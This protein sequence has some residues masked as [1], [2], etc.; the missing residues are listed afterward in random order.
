MSVKENIYS[1]KSCIST[2][3]HCIK[4]HLSKCNGTRV[5]SSRQYVHFKFEPQAMFVFLV[6]CKTGLKESCPSSE[7]LSVYKISRSYVDWCK[8]CIQLSSMKIETNAIYKRL[9]NENNYSNKE[10]CTW[11][12][13]IPRFA[14]LS[15][16]VHQLSPQNKTLILNSHRPPCSYVWFFA[17]VVS[18]KFFYPVKFYE[19]T[20]YNGFTSNDE[21]FESNSLAWMSAVLEW[22]KLRH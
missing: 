22:L 12:Y 19:H 20:K 9:I 18:L 7:E 21:S 17:K 6:S 5:V 16:T 14:C 15:A 8:F 10:V 1:N 11:S 3:F 2:I 13:S 4:L